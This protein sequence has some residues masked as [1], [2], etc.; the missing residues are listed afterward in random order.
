MFEE[1]SAKKR[2]FLNHN[3][4]LDLLLTDINNGSPL[5]QGATEAID[6]RSTFVQVRL[7]LEKSR[8]ERRVAV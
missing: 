2:T 1:S 6:R 8:L 4:A 5:S 7:D 3:N